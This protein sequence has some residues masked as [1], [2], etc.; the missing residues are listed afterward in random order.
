MRSRSKAWRPKVTKVSALEK[1]GIS[2]LWE[3]MQDF[4]ESTLLCGELL[5]RRERQL[6]LW[7]W[8]HIRD[9]IMGRFE[10]QPKVKSMLPVLEDLVVKG[11]VTPG[12]AADYMLQQVDLVDDL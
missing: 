3:M 4:R 12:L 6:K 10:R 9:H 8:N 7:L 5:S 11:H 2:E 1:T